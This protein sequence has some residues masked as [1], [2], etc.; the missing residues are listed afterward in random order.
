MVHGVKVRGSEED[1]QEN[2]R[3]N[4]LYCKEIMHVNRL[5]ASK[6]AK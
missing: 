5:A 3:I 2:E 1:R 6:M 4:K